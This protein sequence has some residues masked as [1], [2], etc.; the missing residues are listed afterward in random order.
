MKKTVLSILNLT[1][2]TPDSY[3]VTL[4]N[5]ESDKRISI[6][7]GAHEAQ[8]ISSAMDSS[9][10]PRP[11]THDT[12][13]NVL[14]HYG[15]II[16]EITIHD[17]I[18]GVFYAEMWCEQDGKM[19][20]FDLRSS[21]AI[22]MALRANIPIHASENVLNRTNTPFP[23]PLPQG[24]IPDFKLP[25]LFIEELQ[26]AMKKAIKTE[27]YEAASLLRDFLK[28]VNEG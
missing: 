3:M 26:L 28:S 17:I 22:A 20:Q 16:K 10:T 18:D 25:R 6:I 23:F 19:Q 11:L 14:E 15:I 8:A 2:P 9:P 12:F 21:D 7:V 5:R 1:S 27:N 4:E 24:E 13:Y